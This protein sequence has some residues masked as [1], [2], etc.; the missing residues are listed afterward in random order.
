M[1]RLGEGNYEIARSTGTCAATGQPLVPGSP[2]VAA[3]VEQE[4][5]EGLLRL[6]YSAEAWDRGER[7]KPPLLLFGYWRGRYEPGEI[8]RKPL[9]ESGSLFEL[10]EQLEDAQEPSRLAFRYILALLL[11]RMKTLR[12]ETTRRDHEPPVMILRRAGDALGQVFEVID[13][14][15]NDEQVAQA[16][17]QLSAVMAD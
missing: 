6:D 16:I 2:F 14:G 17:E 15:M 1:A 4:G 10:F 11:L 12:L 5:D 9:I 3:L 13:P 8:R 7:P